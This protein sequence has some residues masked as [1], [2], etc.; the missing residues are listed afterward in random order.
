MKKEKKKDEQAIKRRRFQ[1]RVKYTRQF[2]HLILDEAAKTYDV[3]RDKVFGRSR[4]QNIILAKRLFIYTLRNLFNLSLSE[5]AKLTNLHH[6]SI[7][8][9]YETADFNYKHYKEFKLKYLAL[10]TIVLRENVDDAIRLVKNSIN[11]LEDEAT[12][13]RKQLTKLNNIKSN[14]NDTEKREDLLTEQY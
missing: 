9:H 11:K 14:N 5:I 2:Y 8:Y 4:K 13:L 7:V 3:D 10:Q 12:E 6:S 1:G